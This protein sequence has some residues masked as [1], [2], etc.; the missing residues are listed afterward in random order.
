MDKIII[1]INSQN[2]PCKLSYRAFKEFESLFKP[3]DQIKSTMEDTARLFFCGLKA[4]AVAEALTFDMN[5]EQFENWLD[6]NMQ[7]LGKFQA[8][9]QADPKPSKK[10]AKNPSA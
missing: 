1:E 10:N 5:F 4:G 6:D 8:L 7:E 9:Q 3:I 2:V